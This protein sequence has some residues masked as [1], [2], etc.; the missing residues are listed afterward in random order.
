MQP[1]ALHC[2]LAQAICS[3]IVL[4]A[5]TATVPAFAQSTLDDARKAVRKNP[6]SP[7]AH[8]NLGVALADADQP[9][10]AIEAFQQAI[11]LNPKFAEAYYSLGM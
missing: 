6:K 10:Q 9:E 1:I 4:C 2:R 5:I 7:I 3:V 8:Y 11:R